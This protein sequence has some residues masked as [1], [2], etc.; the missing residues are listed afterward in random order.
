MRF[1]LTLASVCFG[2]CVYA[3][4]DAIPRNEIEQMFIALAGTIANLIVMVVFYCKL[5]EE[6]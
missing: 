6:K 3:M 1:R 5:K 2:I 4:C